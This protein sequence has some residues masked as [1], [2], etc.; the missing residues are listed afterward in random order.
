V[1]VNGKP[2]KGPIPYG[3][4]VDVTKGKVKL[5]ADVGTLTASGGGGIT[6]VFILLRVKV[7]GKP[8]IEL[9]LTGGTFGVCANASRTSSSLTT[10]EKKPPA[11]VRR[12][13]TKGR[14]S[15]RTRG[16]YASAAIRGTDWL[17]ADR[18]DGTLVKVKQGAVA[19]FDLLLKKTVLVKAGKSYLA[20][21]TV[22]P[23]AAARAVGE[24]TGPMV[25]R[26]PNGSIRETQYARLTVKT[27]AR[28]ANGA[29]AKWTFVQVPWAATAV[30]VHNL[31]LTSEVRPGVVYAYRVPST[32]GSCIPRA[33]SYRMSSLDDRRVVVHLKYGDGLTASGTLARR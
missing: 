29:S 18:C 28:T 23:A 4:K 10:V 13:F 6:A 26:N 16:M 8:F 21:K 2:H 12:L 31:T 24:F 1:L 11:T 17:T 9:R 14:G 27:V 5:K 3:S 7:G 33:E 25:F 15:F 20:K 22:G 30:C 32:T 19:V